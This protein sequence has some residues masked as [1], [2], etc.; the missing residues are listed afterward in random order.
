MARKQIP[1]VSGWREPDIKGLIY[2]FCENMYPIAY[3]G[4]GIDTRA[5]LPAPGNQRFYKIRQALHSQNLAIRG[6][7]SM[8]GYL[9]S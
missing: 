9:G 1:F 5:M 3:P 6:S 7:I 2:E 4:N 8:N